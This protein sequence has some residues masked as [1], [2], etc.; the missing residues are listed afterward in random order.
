MPTGEDYKIKK[1][2]KSLR[3][4]LR[5]E[6]STVS[7]RIAAIIAQK[8][9]RQS[10]KRRMCQGMCFSLPTLEDPFNE[11]PLKKDIKKKDKKSKKPSKG[12]TENG[13]RKANDDRQPNR[14]QKKGKVE[15]GSISKDE[16]CPS[17]FLISC[18]KSIQDML[19]DPETYDRGRPLFFD[20]WGFEFWRCYTT[21]KH[22]LETSGHATVEQI[23]W[24]GSSAVDTYT[25]KEKEGASLIHPYLLYVVPSQER[26]T[27]VRSVCKPLKEF[28]IHTVSLHPGASVDHQIH[29]LKTCEPEFIVCTPDRLLELVSVKAVD[30]SGVF[31]LIIDGLDSSTEDAYLDS[32]K[33]IQQHIS[34][35]PHTVVF[36]S[37]L[38]NTRLP[39][40]SSLLPTPMSK[41]SRDDFSDNKSEDID[42]AGSTEEKL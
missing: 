7:N 23:A 37:G 13:K 24:I 35:D 11:K 27:Q 26:A 1:K 28:G 40:V 4:K 39:A 41:L 20:A 8:K 38:T 12:L 3:K 29:G 2:N 31:S 32:I 17:K 36:C 18:L 16:G 25:R 15:N 19:H 14:E 6:S 22:V 21:G 10:G 5:S 9:R 34:V 42:V 33:S 30:V